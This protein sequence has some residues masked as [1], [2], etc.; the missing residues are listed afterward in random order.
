MTKLEKLKLK[1]DLALKKLAK[2]KAKYDKLIAEQNP[3]EYLNEEQEARLKELQAKEDLTDEEDKELTTLAA[4]AL[5]GIDL[6]DEDKLKAEVDEMEKLNNEMTSKLEKLEA[7][8]KGGTKSPSQNKPAKD[9]EKNT[10]LIKN[11]KDLLGR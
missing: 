1:K 3:A 7:D 6:T 11:V 8:I 10:T 2:K 4:I 9:K 5:N